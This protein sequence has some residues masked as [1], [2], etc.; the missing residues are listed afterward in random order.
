MK[1]DVSYYLEDTTRLNEI[2]QEEL[3]AWINEM[4]FHQPLQ[5]LGNIKSE[6]EGEE[7][8]VK[9]GNYGLYFV[10][11]FESFKEK[12]KKK[13]KKT[14]A[15]VAPAAVE[16]DMAEVEA[17]AEEDMVQLPP[18]DHKLADD[19]KEDEVIRELE[20]DIL[21]IGSKRE[22][23]SEL[24]NA[25]QEEEIISEVLEENLGET[26]SDVVEAE[27]VESID[28]H[29]SD[30]TVASAD[31][32]EDSEIESTT[33][34]E[35]ALATENEGWSQI[36]GQEEEETILSD[37]EVKP[38]EIDEAV[39]E[40]HSLAEKISNVDYSEFAIVTDEKEADSREKEI[41]EA[42]SNEE[43]TSIKIEEP[44]FKT[45]EKKKKTKKKK[46]K[47][48]TE[49]EKP[50]KAKSGKKE[51]KI[52]SKTSKKK[53]GQPKKQK[54][55]SSST[56][57]VS[58][59]SKKSKAGKKGD[60]VRYV[61]VEGS[62]KNKFDLK[63]YDGV[64][65]FTSWLLEQKSID[66]DAE[67]KAKNVMKGKKKKKK[68]KK[69]SKVPKAAIESVK[70]QDSIISEPLADILAAQGHPKKAKK[71]YKKLALV[72]PEK[73]DYYQRKIESLEL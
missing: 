3:N 57:T 44:P 68:G 32:P 63:D 27:K 65:S 54:K 59:K 12:K 11:D 9:N 35:D 34:P 67:V 15:A 36:I 48:K 71:M 46:G 20:E 18:I 66:K 22:V 52:S 37:E 70:K 69:K 51:S 5:L 41:I 19:T 53:E 30:D 14:K 42:V 25:L 43:E 4:P 6:M 33:E 31:E 73:S 61:I 45:I 29:I 21:F 49:E 13:K 16:S 26:V 2:S 28:E 64:S 7:D 56:S 50:I 39:N 60:K 72:F 55:K 47:K 1:K 58:K 24:A 8:D 10:E 23:T 62:D 17:S 38:E 40:E